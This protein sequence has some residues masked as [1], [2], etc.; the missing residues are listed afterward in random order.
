MDRGVLI[1][2]DSRRRLS[3]R[4]LAE[5]EDQYFL[6]Q[7]RPDGSILLTPADVA[8]RRPIVNDDDADVV[9]DA[10]VDL[11][12][13]VNGEESPK[14]SSWWEQRRQQQRESARAKR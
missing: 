3:M 2:L 7:K 10:I 5:E 4:R 14:K 6:A 11:R 12:D 8:P 13:R 1:E 9:T